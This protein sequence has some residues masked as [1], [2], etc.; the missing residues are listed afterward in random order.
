MAFALARYHDTGSLD[1]SFHGDGK[2]ITGSLDPGGITAVAIGDDNRIVVGGWVAPSG[3]PVR[4]GSF[5]LARYTADGDL[6]RSFRGDGTVVTDFRSTR[7]ESVTALCIDHRNR[8]IVDGRASGYFAVAR[9]HWDGAL[10]SS[11]H[12]DGKVLTDFRSREAEWASSVAVDAWGRIVVVGNAYRSGNPDPELALARYREDGRLD[13]SFHGDGKVL[14]DLPSFRGEGVRALAVDRH[15]RIVVGGF[16][17]DRGDVLGETRYFALAR[18]TVD[19]DLDASFGGAGTV[20]TDFRSTEEEEITALAIDAADRIVV[21]GGADDRFALARY[22]DA[23]VLDRTF[24]RDG[25]VITDFRS[26]PHERI[27]GLAIDHRGRIVV[28]GYAGPWFALARYLEDGDLDTSFHGDGKVITD[29]RSSSAERA[30]AIAIDGQGRI[31]AGG[32]SDLS[33]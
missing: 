23:G 25:K 27:E 12:G 17:M 26:T 21:G 5:A 16:A 6:D 9:Y 8:I 18:Y 1:R 29:F 20:I 3:H 30:L 22:T 24:H 2:V 11:F 14:T 13:P 10:D 31:V 32:Y 19:G 4:D 28:A 15:G 7:A 33:A